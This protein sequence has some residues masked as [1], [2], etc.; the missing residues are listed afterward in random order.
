MEFKETQ[1]MVVVNKDVTSVTSGERLEV[2]K[3]VADDSDLRAKEKRQKRT[4]AEKISKAKAEAQRQ[5]ISKVASAVDSAQTP[6][7]VP[8][9]YGNGKGHE[10]NFGGKGNS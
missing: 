6:K 2:S 8:H 10:D 5:G 3:A 1:F 9:G 4:V 7:K